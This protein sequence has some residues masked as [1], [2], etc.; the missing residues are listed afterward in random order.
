[1]ADV[2]K[3][4]GTEMEVFEKYPNS[5]R[6]DHPNFGDVCKTTFAKG[7][8]IDV[9][10][11]LKSECDPLLYYPGKFEGEYQVDPFRV[12]SHVLVQVEGQELW[13]PLFFH[14]KAA[15]WDDSDMVVWGTGV[16]EFT[17][18]PGI[19]A[20]D[21]NRD[22]G[23]FEKAW[24]SFRPGDEVVVIIREGA[25]FAVVGFADGLPR[26][27]EAIFRVN[28]APITG[29]SLGTEVPKYVML[30]E[31]KINPF[32]EIGADGLDLGLVQVVDPII[33]HSYKFR[34]EWWYGPDAG[35]WLHTYNYSWIFP[36]GPKLVVLTQWYQVYPDDLYGDTINRIYIA[37]ATTNNITT[38]QN[39]ANNNDP[40]VIYLDIF[41]NVEG[42]YRQTDI[43]V[44]GTGNLNTLAYT[45]PVPPKYNKFVSILIRPHTKTELE[46]AGMWP[47]VN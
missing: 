23:Y 17:V 11:A 43:I 47:K 5:R 29:S 15:M 33:N 1:M 40:P 3:F 2:V 19:L 18:N 37:T 8:I 24:M 31:E 10:V 4:P 34:S 13:L 20:T 36:L 22:T 21:F 39:I 27:G 46:A 16:N 9:K 14:P 44:S 42:F 41:D 7:V 6:L 35:T 28:V 45:Y 30:A 32:G 38:A 25:P 26:V 12:K